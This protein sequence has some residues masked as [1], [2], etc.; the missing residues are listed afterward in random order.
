MEKISKAEHECECPIHASTLKFISGHFQLCHNGKLLN[1]TKDQEM[2]RQHRREI[3]YPLKNQSAN[4]KVILK[5]LC[6]KLIKNLT[7][8][9]TPMAKSSYC[10]F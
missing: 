3:P 6:K 10:Y 8:L 7:R 1:G 2:I 9:K 5:F 4:K